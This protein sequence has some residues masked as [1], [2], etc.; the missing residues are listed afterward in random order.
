MTD[1]NGSRASKDDQLEFLEPDYSGKLMTTVLALATT[2]EYAGMRNLI[3]ESLEVGG[4]SHRIV[5]AHLRGSD[6]VRPGWI[7]GRISCLVAA[8]EGLRILE[9]RTAAIKLARTALEAHPGA[10][11]LISECKAL[12]S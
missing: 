12:W 11:R 6:R 2:L 1:C 3:W 8:V 5:D 7:A 10:E 4:P 9:G